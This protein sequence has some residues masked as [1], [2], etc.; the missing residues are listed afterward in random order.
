MDVRARLVPKSEERP[1]REAAE[2]PE[3][4]TTVTLPAATAAPAPPHRLVSLDAFRGLTILGML[5]VNN[6][7]LDTRTPAHLVHAPWNE[8]VHFADLVFP[9]FLLIVGV[10]LP[11][12]AASFRRKGLPLRTYVAK[13]LG[14]GITLYLLGCLLTSS[15]ARQPLLGLDVLQ[16][17]ALA[18]CA[19][20]LL[21]ELPLKARLGAAA[22]LLV[23]HWAVIRFLP[24][25]GIGAGAFTEDQNAIAYLNAAYL[26][27]WGAKGLLSVIPTTAMVLIGTGLGDLLRND[28]WGVARKVGGLAAAGLA[29]TAGGWLWSLDLPYNKPVWTASYILLCA[30]LGTLTLAAFYGTIDALRWRGWAFPLVVFGSNAIVAYV[31][32]ILVKIHVL[33]EWVW[34]AAD[35]TPRTV[36]QALLEACTDHFGRGRGGWIYTAGYILCWWLVLLVLYRRKLFLRV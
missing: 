34:S 26:Q 11:Y 23:G 27:A 19:G 25:P 20:A 21:Y 36:Q 35:G 14:R 10:A 5:L 6:V 7:A 2:A 4:E 29:L 24:I 33:Q 12:A 8:G 13:V 32:P 1:R 3:A 28:S 16:L 22:A 15:I 30:G 18:Y 17:I 9:W 31:A